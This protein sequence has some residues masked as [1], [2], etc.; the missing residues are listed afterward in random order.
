MV[1]GVLLH[2][3][4]RI[5][6]IKQINKIVNHADRPRADTTTISNNKMVI[7]V[8]LIVGEPDIIEDVNILHEQVK[9]LAPLKVV[10]GNTETIV[11]IQKELIS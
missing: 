6:V 4:T 7:I 9:D 2:S 10:A 8:K 5:I 3:N 1:G 11:G